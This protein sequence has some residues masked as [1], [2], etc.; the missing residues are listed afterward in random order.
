MTDAAAK[1]ERFLAVAGDFM[2]MVDIAKV[3]KAR[4]GASAEKVPTGNCPIGCCT[5]PRCAIRR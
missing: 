3:L 2:L 4:M 5:S 1:G